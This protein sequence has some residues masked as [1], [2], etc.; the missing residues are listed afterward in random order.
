VV[1]E[2]RLKTR[3]KKTSK[4]NFVNIKKHKKNQEKIRSGIQPIARV[5]KCTT[6]RVLFLKTTCKGDR[7]NVASRFKLI[8]K[9]L[10][11]YQIYNAKGLQ[12]SL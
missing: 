6:D 9:C 7:F 10:R 4:E 11:T 12:L 3:R 1:T 8:A 2:E 5:N